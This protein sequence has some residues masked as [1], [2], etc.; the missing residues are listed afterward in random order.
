MSSE[1]KALLGLF[2]SLAPEQR[3]TLREFAQF[4]A[5]RGESVPAG[6]A[7][8]NPIPRPQQETVVKAIKRLRATYPMLDSG[9]LLHETSHYMS[10]HL[11]QSR[12]AQE[13]IEEL[14]VLFAR[15]YQKL[16]GEQ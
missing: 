8:P 16:K 5:S 13:V 3:R 4:L 7:P 10:Q 14:E 2:R 9:K 1:E 6:I 12:S 15:H 11:M